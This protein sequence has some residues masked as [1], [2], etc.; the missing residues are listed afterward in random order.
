[1][2]ISIIAAMD[3]NRNIGFQGDMPWGSSMKA[4]LKRFKHLT[5]GSIVVMGRKTFESLP[6]ILPNR[7]H[8]VLSTNI[9]DSIFREDVLYAKS[10]DETLGYIQHECWKHLSKNG[11]TDNFEVFIIGG[12]NV[13]E[14][15]MEYADTIYLTVIN[16]YL[17]GDTK[18]PSIQGSWDVSEESYS[19]DDSNPYAYTFKTYKRK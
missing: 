16:A 3:K 18:F 19:S 5:D 11:T 7:K 6:G 4:D 15:F 9:D 8:I 2:G 17:D 13:Y 1:M 14:Q 12:A 10:V